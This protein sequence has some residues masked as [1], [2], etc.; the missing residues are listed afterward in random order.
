M[1]ITEKGKR[2]ILPALSN[3]L[4]EL[5]RHWCIGQGVKSG[6]LAKFIDAAT[7][8]GK[9]TREIKRYGIPGN[10]K[11]ARFV[12]PLNATI[13]D[14]TTEQQWLQNCV[15]TFKNNLRDLKGAL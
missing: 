8:T 10:I 1:P 2:I 14:G 7:K 5:Y 15:E 6:S 11:Q 12:Y 4:Y 13:P 3:D 9:L